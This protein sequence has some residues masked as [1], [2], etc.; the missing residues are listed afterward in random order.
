MSEGWEGLDEPEKA[1]GGDTGRQPMTEEEMSPMLNKLKVAGLHGT[2][3]II[4]KQGRELLSLRI[5]VERL[6]GEVAAARAQAL[7][8]AA[9]ECMEQLPAVGASLKKD[10]VWRAKKT[11][12]ISA[13]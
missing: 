1:A 11:H 4:V 12:A 8:E 9:R 6:Q 3:D 13:R 7:V 2:S 10:T 5:E